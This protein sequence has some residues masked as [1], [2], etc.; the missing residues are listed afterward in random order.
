MS[1]IPFWK[2]H[3]AGNDFI[4]IDDRACA[5]SDTDT[6]WIEQIGTRRTGV[7]CD[8][9]MLIRPSTEADFRMRF[10]NPDGSEVNMCGNGA[11]CIARLASEVGAAGNTMSIETGAGILQ[12]ELLGD[13]VRVE[14]TPPCDWR[15]ERAVE[16]DG[17]RVDYSFVNTGVEHVVVEVEDLDGCELQRLG[18]GIRYHADFAPAGTN[19]NFVSVTGERSLR[20]RT[21]ERGVEGETQA[22][23]TGI[24]ASALVMARR[25]RVQA[26][27]AVTAASGDVLEVDF[28]L[29]DDGAG[30]VTLLGPTVH[31]YTGT[32]SYPA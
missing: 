15:M 28:T 17:E 3:G 1:E 4:V 13:R 7:G 21:Y 2:M 18:A 24:T 27:V 26:P 11:R 12:A 25:G 30:K 9:I 22:C 16:V 5:F 32:L 20:V 31:V 14:L 6:R 10:F 29:S 8:G 19:A 23:G